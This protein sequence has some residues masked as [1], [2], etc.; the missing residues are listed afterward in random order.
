M[1]SHKYIIN[2]RDIHEITVL[3]SSGEISSKGTNAIN[4]ENQCHSWSMFECIFGGSTRLYKSLR[5]LSFTK[6]ALL[7]G[8][9]D[10]VNPI[11]PW[12]LLLFC[13][14]LSPSIPVRPLISHE[15]LGSVSTCEF[16]QIRLESF[17]LMC[18]CCIQMHPLMSQTIAYIRFPRKE[19]LV[20]KSSGLWRNRYNSFLTA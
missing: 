13:L 17:T 16:S 19:L 7:Q 14:L 20:Q 12:A 1:L 4:T 9:Q 5:F 2:C 10:T 3:K 15:P 11:P 6:G 18:Q 8:R